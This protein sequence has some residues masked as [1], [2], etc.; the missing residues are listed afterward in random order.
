V[1]RLHIDIGV[2]VRPARRARIGAAG[3]TADQRVAP[4]LAR[5][6]VAIVIDVA[7]A[8]K[9]R[10]DFL[11]GDLHE[12]A[13]ARALALD[14]RGHDRGRG[15]DAGARVADGGAAA[16]RLAVGEPRDAHHT[17]RGLRD[18]VE[19]LVLGVRP[20]ETEALDARDDDARVG[21]AQALVVE[22]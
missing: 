8:Q 3:D 9:V 18:H 17:A 10:D 4:A 16:D 15:V 1:H 14:I 6:V 13:L 7:T 11:H 19:A 2:L 5:L 20:G 12:L 21:R 22:A